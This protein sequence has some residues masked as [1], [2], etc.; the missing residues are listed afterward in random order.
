MSP[1]ALACAS[2]TRLPTELLGASP[3]TVGKGQSD[4]THN[5]WNMSTHHLS[6]LSVPHD[7]LHIYTSQEGEVDAWCL[8]R[9]ER[10]IKRCWSQMCPLSARCWESAACSFSCPLG[11]RFLLLEVSALIK[12]VGEVAGVLLTHSQRRGHAGL[13]AGWQQHGEGLVGRLPM[14]PEAVDA[15]VL[16]VAPVS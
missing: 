7:M 13:P 2:F 5:S 1:M 10:R 11:Q 12:H 15:G 6:C 14:H 4:H 8:A 3:S 9:G 16:R